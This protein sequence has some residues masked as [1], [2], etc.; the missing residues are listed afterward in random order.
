MSVESKVRAAA[1]PRRPI[2]P[3]PLTHPGKV[4]AQ[5]LPIYLPRLP[6]PPLLPAQHLLDLLGKHVLPA[7]LDHILGAPEQPK[8]AG[9]INVTQVP[10]P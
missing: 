3:R 6:I 9:P 2:F 7:A 10:S 5:H 4:P 1:L 8:Q